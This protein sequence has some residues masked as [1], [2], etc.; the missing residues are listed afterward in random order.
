MIADAA[1][2]VAQAVATTLGQFFESGML[3]CFGVSWPVA[4]LKTLRSKQTQGKS[5]GFLVLV[6]IGYLSGVA[7]KFSRAADGHWPEPVTILYAI[8]A[9]LVMTDLLLVRHYR[10]I[11]SD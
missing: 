10:R 6:F 5:I 3:I 7:A 4:I 2:G 8:N 11:G 9:A 1:V